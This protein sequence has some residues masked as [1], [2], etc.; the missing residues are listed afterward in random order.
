MLEISFYWLSED[1]VRFYRSVDLGEMY[2]KN[3]TVITRK[4][5]LLQHAVQR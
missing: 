1:I 2:Y 4:M 5:D 3:V